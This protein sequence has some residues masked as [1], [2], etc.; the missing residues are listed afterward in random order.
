MRVSFR[1]GIV[2][3]QTDVAQSMQFLVRTS[4]GVT[5]YVSPTPTTINF[6]HGNANYL[7][8]ESRT[9]ENAWLG[10]FANK[11]TWLYWDLNTK[12]G[13]RT[14]G[15]TA[16]APIVG[17][18]QPKQPAVGQHWFNTTNTTMYE[19]VGIWNPVIRV[20]AAK[21]KAGT[22][23]ESMADIP[24]RINFGGSQV[25][26]RQVVDAGAIMYDAAGHPLK[27]GNGA[28]YT[29]TDAFITGVP[30]NA[31]VKIESVLADGIADEAIPAYSVVYFSDF[32]KLKLANAYSSASKVV[33]IVSVDAYRGMDVQ[34]TTNG[35]VTNP[36]WAWTAV[37]K[38]VYVNA[39]G[40]IVD[41]PDV[42]NQSPIGIVIDPTTIS[43]TIPASMLVGNLKGEKGDAGPKGEAGD[44][45]ATGP[46]G[47]TGPQG[48]QGTRG[49]EGAVGPMG[50]KGEVGDRGPKGDDG[51]QGATGLPGEASTVAGPKGDP[52][53]TGPAGTP[54]AKGDTGAAGPM[55]PQGA[56]GPQGIAGPQGIQ[57]F[58]GERGLASTVAGPQG[59]IGLTGPQG[60]VGPTGPI[61]PTG[62]IGEMGPT[63]PKGD[64]GDT[65]PVGPIGAPSTVQGPAGPQG[66][67]GPQGPQ[68]ARGADGIQGIQGLPGMEG[69]MGPMPN[70]DPFLNMPPRAGYPSTQGSAGIVPVYADFG[71]SRHEA[72]TPIPMLVDSEDREVMYQNCATGVFGSTRVYRSYRY[73]ADADFVVDSKPMTPLF[74]LA[75]EELMSIYNAS[76]YFVFAYVKNTATNIIRHVLI[77]TE[78]SS[79]EMDWTSDKVIDITNIDDAGMIAT[80]YIY[81]HIS[82]RIFQI[83]LRAVQTEVWFAAYKASDQTLVAGPT[84][85]VSVAIGGGDINFTDTFGRVP[86]SECRVELINGIVS[87]A[88]DSYTNRLYSTPHVR[89]IQS[90]NGGPP[91]YIDGAFLLNYTLPANYLATGAGAPVNNI[92]FGV[93]SNYYFYLRETS[94]NGFYPHLRNGNGLGFDAYYRKLYLNLIDLWGDGTQYGFAKY[95]LSNDRFLG[96]LHNAVAETVEIDY[97]LP[98]ASPWSKRLYYEMSLVNDSLQ[99]IGVSASTGFSRVQTKISL[100]DVTNPVGNIDANTR[101][102]KIIPNT[103]RTVKEGDSE[104]N[105]VAYAHL[106]TTVMKPDKSYVV[107]QCLDVNTPI[108]V[109]SSDST[110]RRTF[111]PSGLTLPTIPAEYYWHAGWTWDGNFANPTFY[112][113]VFKKDEVG[114]P[115][116]QFGYILKLSGG[117]YTLY[118]NVVMQNYWEASRDSRQQSAYLYVRAP[119]MMTESGKIGMGFS[120]AVLGTVTPIAYTLFNPADGTHTVPM[121]SLVADTAGSAYLGYHQTLGYYCSWGGQGYGIYKGISVYCSKNFGTDSVSQSE[122]AFF[123]NRQGYPRMVSISPPVGLVAYIF[124]TPVF[125][126]GYCSTVPNLTVDLPPNATSYVYLRRDPNDRTGYQTLV[127]DTKLP[128]SF[129]R[130]AIAKVVTDGDHVI[131]SEVYEIK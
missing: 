67:V 57:G 131:D 73:N 130:I 12:T 7:F 81:D 60:P 103:Y 123:V 55:G 53:D 66:P 127:L 95:D 3:Y 47:P 74:L 70:Y 99:F 79:N 52:G 65:G 1:Q 72:F 91:E 104:L 88:Y 98:D 30:T 112:Y 114:T 26:N 36:A 42:A 56:Q 58:Q 78:G 97:A 6:A 109:V 45:G 59:P 126:G 106:M 54:G 101:E 16:I 129:T 14:F 13:V 25:S 24:L 10:N 92:P 76:T 33:G 22:T 71:F 68:G 50:P 102:F 8:T 39:T 31:S 2:S 83:G 44:I 48:E 11:D 107:Y 51:I 77:K 19:W 116:D 128:N 35:I 40:K 38:L 124:P 113:H 4:A 20:F 63:G 105:L 29:T 9:V 108:Y 118:P 49:Y 82:D 93:A 27:A 32:S 18:V 46:V 17:S 85:L 62:A 28:F 5:L 121:N 41:T 87:A 110:G 37:N 80:N 119:L 43:M 89:L 15:S 120:W 69:P 90:T 86:I 64:K 122:T 115:R 23:F 61:G 21:L 84:R 125:L 96:T 34:V 75:N 94:N 117:Q 100:T 111:T